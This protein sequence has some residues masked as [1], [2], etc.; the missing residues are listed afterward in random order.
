MSHLVW[1]R[2]LKIVYSKQSSL[3]SFGSSENTEYKVR[4]RKGLSVY[5]YWPFPLLSISQK[6]SVIFPVLFHL[7]FCIGEKALQVW[8]SFTRSKAVLMYFSFF[9]FLFPRFLKKKM[10][11]FRQ[12][13]LFSINADIQVP[14]L[15]NALTIK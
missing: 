7:L 12:K 10:L 9:S 14:N 1:L 3:C 8:G 2:Y 5:M 4:I 15:K 11:Q 6:A 13:L